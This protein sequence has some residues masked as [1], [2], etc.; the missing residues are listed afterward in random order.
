MRKTSFGFMESSGEG[1][2]LREK[3]TFE[4]TGRFHKHQEIE[5]FEVLS[6]K[7]LLF[8]ENEVS[9]IEEGGEYTVPSGKLHKMCPNDGETLMVEVRYEEALDKV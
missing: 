4:K 5:I 9:S 2:A 8:I 7:G 3:L 1:K 6:G